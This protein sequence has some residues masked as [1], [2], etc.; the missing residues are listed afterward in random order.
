MNVLAQEVTKE[1]ELIGYIKHSMGISPVYYLIAV[2]IFL[3]IYKTWKKISVSLLITYCFLIFATTVLARTTRENVS[4]NLTPFRLFQIDEWWA[5]HD[6]MLQIRANVLMFVPIGFLLMSAG[7]GIKGKFVR[8]LYIIVSII[9]GVFFSVL[10]EYMQYRLHRGLCEADDV[11]H[12]TIGI[13]IGIVL[14]WIISRIYTEL[15]NRD[16]LPHRNN[17]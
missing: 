5:K 7:K 8:V 10:I 12:N 6:L 11:I 4:Y 14:Y 17:Q 15:D 9:A 2:A 1:D 16:I 13:A 3:L